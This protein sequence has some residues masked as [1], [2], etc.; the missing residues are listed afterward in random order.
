MQISNQDIS[1]L[2]EGKPPSDQQLLR[3]MTLG[4]E[5]W[6]DKFK[7]IYLQNYICNGGSKVKV[8]IGSEGCGKTHLLRLI[9]CEANELGYFTIYFSLFRFYFFISSS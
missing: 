3:K 1:L 5:V 9:E 8:L 7:N 6:L 4:T 2:K